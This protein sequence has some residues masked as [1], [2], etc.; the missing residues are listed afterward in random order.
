MEI[1]DIPYREGAKVCREVDIERPELGLKYGRV[2]RVYSSYD[3]SDCRFRYP[4]MYSV[5]WSDGTVGEGFLRH[6]I[7]PSQH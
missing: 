7:S 2:N 4:E 6:G 3:R 1:P 5:I